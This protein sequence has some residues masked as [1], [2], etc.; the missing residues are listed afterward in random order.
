[1]FAVFRII[2]VPKYS[3]YNLR[4]IL[5][6]RA[7]YSKGCD[8]RLILWERVTYSKGC[9]LRSILWERVTYLKGMIS[10]WP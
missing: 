3:K 4:L 10:E 6:E 9:D 5:W 2:H 1:M 8:L 7:T